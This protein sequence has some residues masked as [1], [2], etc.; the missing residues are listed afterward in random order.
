LG[1]SFALAIDQLNADIPKGTASASFAFL[2]RKLGYEL[3]W[4][5]LSKL[6]ALPAPRLNLW[7]VAPGLRRLEY[8][9]RLA[10]AAQTSCTIDPAEYH[11][12]GIPYQLYRCG[13]AP[14]L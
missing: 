11:R 5:K 14:G 13:P 3:V 10:I 1:L 4:Q 8:P 7:V 6:P 12:I 9:Q 2:D